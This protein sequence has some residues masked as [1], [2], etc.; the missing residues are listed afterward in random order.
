MY[1]IGVGLGKAC[2]HAPQL[3]HDLG[4]TTFKKADLIMQHSCPPLGAQTDQNHT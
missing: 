1:L 4:T 3:Q 2:A